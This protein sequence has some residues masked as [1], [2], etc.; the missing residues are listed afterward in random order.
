M[1]NNTK[2]LSEKQEIL[3]RRALRIALGVMKNNSILATRGIECNCDFST[4][5]KKICN[6]I[7]CKTKH[8]KIYPFYFHCT[9]TIQM[10]E[11]SEKN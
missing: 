6:K 5:W 3:E 10:G 7:L 1:P 9:E 4:R 2:A 11:K 8:N